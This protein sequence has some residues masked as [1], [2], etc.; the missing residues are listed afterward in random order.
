MREIDF[1]QLPRPIQDR[2]IG[3]TQ[4]G[5]PSPIMVARPKS[6]RALTWF[7]CAAAALVATLAVARLG[8]GSLESAFALHAPRLIPLYVALTACSV[9]CLLRGLACQKRES[10]APYRPW[11]Y[12]FPIGIVDARAPKLRV[13]DVHEIESLERSGSA[14]VSVRVSSGEQFVFEVGEPR[15]VE[16]AKAVLD[17]ARRAVRQADETQSRRDRAVLDPL[18]DTGFSNPFSPKTSLVR[19]EPLRLL[20]T[21]PLALV[22]G[23]VLGAGIW[24]LR[25]STSEQ[26]LYVRAR[27]RD[28][29]AGYRAYLARGGHRAD[30]LDILLPRA[31]L[32]AVRASGNLAAIERF[33]AAHPNSKISGEI[34]AAHRDVLLELLEQAKAAG[35]ISALDEFQRRNPQHSLVQRELGHA[36]EQVYARA[37]KKFQAQA[38]DEEAVRFFERLLVYARQHGPDVQIRFQRRLASSTDSIERGLQKNPYFMGTVSLPSQ[39]FDAARA[40]RREQRAAQRLV[41]RFAETF[42]P[43]VLKLELGAPLPESEQIPASVTVPTLFI[44]HT[45]EMNGLYLSRNP[46]GIFVGMGIL[47]QSVFR[48]PGDA[49]PLE[50]KFSQWRPPE[51]A[52][53]EREGATIEQVYEATAAEAFER[54][55]KRF[56]A[57]VFARQPEPPQPVTGR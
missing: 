5:V 20:A 13:F 57:S 55:T 1:Y 54:F 15:N 36:R 56:I 10:M 19:K 40:R 26:R 29:L 30:V 47:F 22:L 39:Y 46:R 38:Q 16:L 32:R 50:V 12:F 25:N 27:Q 18:W 48:V 44:K 31:E 49:K 8:F 21:V 34:A 41:A 17:E 33:I 11:V 2:F 53:Y 24:L 3:A 6:R 42:P 4:G 14:G 45:L 51:L 37:F 28:E 35:T 43:D 7:T 9:F 52:L 23:V